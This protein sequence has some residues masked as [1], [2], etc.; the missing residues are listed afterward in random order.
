MWKLSH[1][2]YASK[3]VKEEQPFKGTYD[4]ASKKVTFIISSVLAYIL[5]YSND[6]N[7]VI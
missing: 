3:H 1:C 4:M 6:N 7:N 2:G 5:T